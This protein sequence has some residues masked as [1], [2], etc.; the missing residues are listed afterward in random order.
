MWTW[1]QERGLLHYHTPQ[2]GSNV[3]ILRFR[4]KPGAAIASASYWTELVRQSEEQHAFWLH[5]NRDFEEAIGSARVN[6]Q[7]DYETACREYLNRN[8]AAFAQFN[9]CCW[10]S[11]FRLL[12]IGYSELFRR[13]FV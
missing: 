10:R 3:R 6:S 7:D 5:N 8:A 11:S 12:L 1:P 4:P 2:D 13:I 9:R